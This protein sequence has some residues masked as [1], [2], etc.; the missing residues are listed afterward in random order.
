MVTTSG[1]KAQKQGSKFEK[2]FGVYLEGS[3]LYAVQPQLTLDRGK[4]DGRKAII[5]AMVYDRSSSERIIC[6]CKSQTSSGSA[7]EKMVWELM[8]LSHFVYTKQCERAYMIVLGNGFSGF[9][10]FIQSP[11]FRTFMPHLAWGSPWGGVTIAGMD[12][13]VTLINKGKL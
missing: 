12:D 5:D 7:E 9:K 2:F 8:L 6:S 13:I 3:E 1:G 10:R 11:S 4:P